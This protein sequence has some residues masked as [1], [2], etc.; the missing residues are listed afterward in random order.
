MELTTK[1]EIGFSLLYHIKN[2]NY[3]TL[4]QVKINS[5]L[6][7]SSPQ[8]V[9]LSLIPYPGILKYN[10]PKYRMNYTHMY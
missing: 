9:R 6:V 10:N 7:S 1:L 2:S 3:H 8:S 5:H 4:Q